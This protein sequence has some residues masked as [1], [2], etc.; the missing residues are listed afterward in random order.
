MKKNTWWV[1]ITF[2][3][4]LTVL[5]S[6]CEIIYPP[7]IYE[8]TPTKINYEL[9][10]GYRVNSTGM[11]LYEITYF[12][13]TPEVL[14]GTTTYTLLYNNEYQTRTLVNNTFIYWNIS[15]KDEKTFE[16]G[17]TT[18][19]EAASFLIADLNGEDALTIRQINEM[20]PKILNQYTR[21]QTNETI[22]FI[23]P[24]DPDITIIANEV[25]LNSKTNN[26]FL[27]AKSLFSWLKQ[28][29]QYQTHPNEKVVRSA[30]L[31][32]SKKQGDC[33][34]LS[35]LYISLC[36]TL[37][38][39]AR[40]VRGYLLTENFNGTVTVTAH[41]WTEVF[42][43]V[44]D[45]L[46]GWIPIECAC[47]SNSIKTDIDQN[48]GVESAF[49]LRL[50]TDDGSNESLASMLSGISYITHEPNTKI[51]IQAFSQIRNYQE[52]ESKKLIITEK[53]IRHYE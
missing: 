38:I 5:L 16:L 49:H 42:V 8:A 9:S 34:D 28:H 7:V 19:V 50:F 35:F 12:C 25:L 18:E 46:D 3:L 40:F 1:F 30:A 43:G 27:L 26:S 6:G 23:D 45:S 37:G 44:T 32:L 13:D 52:L 24:H 20:Y 21:L 15:S 14:L 10:Y 22:R 2:M 31:T 39:P 48:F 17:I 29:V 36:R 33:D 4:V 51:Q 41:A 11:G 53:N 47:C